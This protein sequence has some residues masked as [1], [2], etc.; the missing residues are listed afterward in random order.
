MQI[1]TVISAAA[2]AIGAMGLALLLTQQSYRDVTERPTEQAAPVGRPLK[3]TSVIGL[4]ALLPYETLSKAL[5][6]AIPSSFHVE[7]RRQIC[8]SLSEAAANA[9]NNTLGGDGG[10]V[11]AFFTKLWVQVS[12][13][14]AGED[15]CF[16]GD[17]K[18]TITREGEFIAGLN[19][20][21]FHISVPIKVNGTVGLAGDGAKVFGLDKK[22]VRGEVLAYADIAMQIDQNWCPVMQVKP[23][24]SWRDPAKV[25]L[26][27]N[28]WLGIDS[29]ATEK[30]TQGINEGQKQLPA[31]VSCDLV[32]DKVKPLWH[33]H[34]IG[35]PM[36]SGVEGAVVVTPLRIGLSG[37]SNTPN[38]MQVSLMLEASTEVLLDKAASPA[39]ETPA[40]VTLPT[41][42]QIPSAADGFSMS[43]PVTVSYPSLQ[44]LLRIELMKKPFT[45]TSKVAEGS[46][47]VKEVRTFPAGDRLV[48]GIRFDSELSR[49][50][51]LAPKGWVYITARPH[52]DP[53][54][55]TLTLGDLSYSR[56]IDNDLWNA[57][58]YV[59]QGP[60]RALL[61]TGAKIDM[62]EKI[63][64]VQSGLRTQIVE[65]LHKSGLALELK[66]R[67]MKAAMVEV[68]EGGVRV[69]IKFEGA[70]KVTVR[71][72]AVEAAMKSLAQTPPPAPSVTSVPV[73]VAA[74]EVRPTFQSFDNPRSWKL[75]R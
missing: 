26:M 1:K 50:K 15:K 22:N 63:A 45:F 53:T 57:V 13:L 61:E 11:A 71:P 28:W 52:F 75:N 33:Q 70:A 35:L 10:K 31:L 39:V 55:Q 14:R 40:L 24:F 9:V 17:Y 69:V 25:E 5:N 38:G 18:A 37:L 72:S 36:E 29:Q 60:I 58:S 30:I 65:V 62:Q 12:T 32:K 21:A 42:Q 54:T 66:D 6:T 56:I 44:E 67:P 16:D 20:D 27:G 64:S 23:G 49:P 43:I 2:I 73:P 46:L 74:V 68:L 48:L 8:G 51:S 41:L 47:T 3:E 34:V 59:F 7:G 19:G 4:T